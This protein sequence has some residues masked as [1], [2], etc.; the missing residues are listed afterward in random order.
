MWRSGYGSSEHGPLAVQAVRTFTL[1][2]A[3][4]A[5]H[6]SALH[7]L[8]GAC[9]DASWAPALLAL[10]EAHLGSYVDAA[11]KGN[12]AWDAA[13]AVWQACTAVFTAGEARAHILTHQYPV[14]L[15]ASDRLHSRPWSRPDSSRAQ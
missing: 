1:P 5:A 13:K 14:P 12:L 3:A 10:C 6:V 2:P 4:A 7:Q 9:G 8:S 11:S 15:Y